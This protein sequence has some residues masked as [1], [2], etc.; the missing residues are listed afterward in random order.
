MQNVWRSEAGTGLVKMSRHAC[1][2]EGG[3]EAEYLLDDM[4]IVFLMRIV[5]FILF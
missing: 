1:L 3:L 5:I 4:T 2:A